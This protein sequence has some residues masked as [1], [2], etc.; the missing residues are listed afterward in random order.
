MTETPLID[1]N[2]IKIETEWVINGDQN[3]KNMEYSI[4]KIKE[5]LEPGELKGDERI[6]VVCFGPSLKQEWEKLKDF[7]WIIT[8]S[9]AH[10]F[11]IE[12]GIIPTWHTDVDPRKHK[13][14]LMG[15]PHPDVTYLPISSAHHEYID[16]LNGYKTLLWHGFQGD[17]LNKLPIIY[18]R[19]EW[20][21]AGG[22]TAGL[23]TLL[24]AR[25]LGFT[26]IDLFGMDCSYPP[27][28]VGEHA[29]PHPNPSKDGLKFATMFEGV[30]YNTTAGMVE[31]AKQ[32]FSEIA[33][34]KDC[35]IMMHGDGLLQHM[36]KSG[37][38]DPT[39][40]PVH[41]AGVIAFKAPYL[42]T[43]EYLQL[44]K[45]LHL[46]NPNY[47]VSGSK[48]AAE[49]LKLSNEYGSNDILDY[50][51]GKGTLQGALGFNI[52]EY[53]PAI[54]G[55]DSNP[56]PAD[57][58]VCTDVLEHIEPEFIDWVIG[59]VARCTK[60]V[61]YIVIHTGPA[62][63]TLR[64]GRNA[65]LIQE[66][67]AWWWKKLNVQF[68]IDEMIEE[69]SHI[70][71]WCNP[72]TGKIPDTVEEFD[73][74]QLS[75][76]YEV[77]DGVKYVVVNQHTK[78]RVETLRT[79]EP[80]TISWLESMSDSDIL[81]DVGANVGMYTLWAAKNR[82]VKVYAF[83][84]E[85]QN[86]A[87]LTQNIFLNELS[88]SI[89]WFNA[90]IGDRVGAGELGLTEFMPGSSCHQFD[91]AADWQGKPKNF[92]AKQ[93]CFV[94]T[95]DW[96]MENCGLPQPTHIKIDIDGLEPKVIYGAIRTLRNVKSM[97]IEVNNT[98][99]EHQQMLK[100]LAG[101]GFWYDN[102]QVNQALRKN[103]PFVGVGE[104]VFRRN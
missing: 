64:D 11:L 20:V 29:A 47:G 38:K 45:E 6:A 75:F 80:S 77:A 27:D 60:K 74:E 26:K 70:K 100:L 5:R 85:S 39:F 102:N 4:S 50:G 28:N 48:Y 25:F 67:K 69:G 15:Q 71:A 23:R 42:Y 79:K 22:C 9:G 84:A 101:M 7:K 19:G 56:E 55:K 94:F 81:W 82:G 88:E 72:R 103:G 37:W 62:Q 90:A 18:P 2:N 66:N 61:A 35:E 63:K 97:L 44:N 40:N 33:L 65:H 14:E 95:I 24:I 92:E 53:D 93:P 51:C 1:I 3:I 13:I 86:Y 46:S 43:Q 83:E 36:A 57:I 31:A 87:L 98:L 30:K 76:N 59:D 17:D 16:H 99:P 58:V 41:V 21:F 104:Y 89:K 54:P 52:K 91:V 73:K 68:K 34:L 49:V 96:L 32:F 78:W 12:R 8:C 10:K